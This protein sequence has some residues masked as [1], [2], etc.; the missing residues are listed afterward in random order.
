V[1]SVGLCLDPDS[2]LG[3]DDPLENVDAAMYVLKDREES[4][5][6]AF[7]ENMLEQN[8]AVA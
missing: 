7:A 5:F 4:A 6:P 8:G 3:V 1:G 2:G